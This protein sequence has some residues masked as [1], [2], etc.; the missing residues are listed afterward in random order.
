MTSLH[1]KILAFASRLAFIVT[2]VSAG[3]FTLFWLAA[4]FQLLK[5]LEISTEAIIGS[6]QLAGA[7]AMLAGPLGVA[8]AITEELSAGLRRRAVHLFADVL[9]ATPSTTL[10]IAAVALA[11]SDLGLGFELSLWGAA[12]LLSFVLC[13]VVYKRT[14]RS[15]AAIDPHT[16]QAAIALGAAPLGLL[17][18]FMLPAARKRIFGGIFLCFGR[19]LGAA[20]LPFAFRVAGSGLHTVTLEGL[21]GGRIAALQTIGLIALAS[22]SIQIIDTFVLTERT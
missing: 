21:W 14:R 10:A 12:L 9:S 17:A 13:P 15:I 3:S 2:L 18:K 20:A 7:A 6:L 4:S 8:L 11:Y 16:R 19:G 1:P 22:W 5:P